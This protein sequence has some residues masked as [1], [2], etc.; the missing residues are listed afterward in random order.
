ME[1]VR[2]E[3]NDELKE[4]LCKVGG[5]PLVVGPHAVDILFVQLPEAS[6]WCGIFFVPESF[7]NVHFILQNTNA[8][9]KRKTRVAKQ[10]RFKN[11]VE[12]DCK[13]RL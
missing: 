11:S 1:N 12:H 9:H 8:E 10:N 2:D 3:M 6:K 4:L 5:V 7:K 13:E